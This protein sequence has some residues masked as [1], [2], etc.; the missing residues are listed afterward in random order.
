MDVK[1]NAINRF[2]RKFYW[3]HTRSVGFYL[4]LIF[5]VLD[6]DSTSLLVGFMDKIFY[7]MCDNFFHSWNSVFEVKYIVIADKWWT[8][9]SESICFWENPKFLCELIW[10]CD[11]IAGKNWFFLQFIKKICISVINGSIKNKPEL[12]TII[13]HEFWKHTLMLLSAS[14]YLFIW[15]SGEVKVFQM[16]FYILFGLDI[17]PCVINHSGFSIER[18]THDGNFFTL[19]VVYHL[20]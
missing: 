1:D 3:F 16:N 12:I 2:F 19:R 8:N 6:F 20:V 18:W 11:S 9:M 17:L 7:S 5:I 15:K 13:F 14:Q 4:M 10:P